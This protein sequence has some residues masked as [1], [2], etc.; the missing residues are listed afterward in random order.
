MAS[1]C[2]IPAWRI[3]CTEEPGGLPTIR[4]GQRELD[5]T[6]QLN[7][8]NS[9]GIELWHLSKLVQIVES[10]FKAH[11][12]CIC[13]EMVFRHPRMLS[14]T[15]APR[16]ASMQ[17]GVPLGKK[18]PVSITTMSSISLHTV[19]VFFFQGQLTFSLLKV[20]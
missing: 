16:R 6:Q 8:G 11:P 18:N 17:N 10:V 4:R 5:M 19:T 9:R 20:K 12:L 7:K 15:H 13:S 1:H 14:D 2:S 3:P